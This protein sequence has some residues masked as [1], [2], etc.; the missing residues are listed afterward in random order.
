MRR[1]VVVLSDH[2]MSRLG[3]ALTATRDVKPV[4]V[5]RLPAEERLSIEDPSSSAP[6]AD[7]FRWFFY[8]SNPP[9]SNTRHSLSNVRALQKEFLVKLRNTYSFFVIYANIDG[10]VPTSQ[11]H[12][13]KNELDHWIESELAQTVRAVTDRMDAYDVYGATQKLIDFVDAL[14]NW[15]VRRSRERFWRSGMDPNKRAA[16]ETLY[17]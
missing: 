6:G 5:P 16:Y 2:D 17:A 3:V 12:G 7:A 13:V 4:E 10:W 8:A 1:R 14:S 15:W 9:W 11:A